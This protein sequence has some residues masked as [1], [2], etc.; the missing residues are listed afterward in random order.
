MNLCKSTNIAVIGTII[1]L[2][3]GIDCFSISSPLVKCN[4]SANTS[5]TSKTSRIG[6]FVLNNDENGEVETPPVEPPVEVKE[7]LEKKMQ[8][9]EASEE[10]LKKASLGG[11]VQ[12]GSGTDGFD[13][14]LYFAFPI[15]VLTS[16]AFAF[17]PF[18]MDKIDVTSVGPPPT[19]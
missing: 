19:V 17:F 15:I 7:S 13:I 2:V 1:F 4:V 16:L 18:I 10:E 6:R 8:K 5:I 12:G 9:W 14:G 3:C 11:L